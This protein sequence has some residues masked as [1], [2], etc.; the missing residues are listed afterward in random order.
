MEKNIKD[1]KI[2]IKV[3]ETVAAGV[4]SN[5]AN[6]THSA[7]EYILDFLFINPTPP[8]GFGKLVSRIVMTPGHAKRILYALSNNIKNYEEK[9][10]EIKVSQIPEEMK[11]KIQ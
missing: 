9:F 11:D 10:G 7:E 8:P 4:F 5:F 1:V 2:E 6:I 3:D